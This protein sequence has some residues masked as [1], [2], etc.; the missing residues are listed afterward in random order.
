M[1]PEQAEM[2][3]QDVD[4]RTDVYSLG[5][6][7]YE[8]L[9]G[10]TPLDLR[11][12]RRAGLTEICRRIRE[13]EPPKPSTRLTGHG[14]TSNAA[15]MNRRTDL[16]TLTRQLRKDL[17]WVTMKAL[18]KDRTRRYASASELSAPTSL[19]TFGTSP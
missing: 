3:G 12:L 14:G 17:D 4:T 5:V 1:S 2:T 16:S 7:L 13:D 6:L 18:D 8:L 11:E 19:A 10:E 15:A 9:V